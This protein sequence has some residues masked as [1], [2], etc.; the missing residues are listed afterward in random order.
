MK[1]NTKNFGEIEINEGDIIYFP[2]GL[3]AFEA[4][5]KFVLLGNMEEDTPFCWLQSVER[6]ELAFVVVDPRAVKPDYEADVS[7]DD[8]KLLEIEGD[9]RVLIY[10]I[11]VIPEDIS[12]MTANLQ[13]PILIN[14]RNNK[15]KQVVLQNSRYSIRHFIAEET[16]GGK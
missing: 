9:S 6:G 7:D 16:G 15:A 14:T 12:K 1:L 10:S 8:I 11:V 2:E 13:A 3:P 4:I 5:N